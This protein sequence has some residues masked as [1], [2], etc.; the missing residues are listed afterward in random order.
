M[1]LVDKMPV[2]RRRT[3]DGDTNSVSVQA[4]TLQKPEAACVL[5]KTAD[6]QSHAIACELFQCLSVESETAVMF[7]RY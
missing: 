2:R 6:W 3:L 4:H 7:W 1:R 5:M